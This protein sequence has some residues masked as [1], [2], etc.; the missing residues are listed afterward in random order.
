MNG[1][2]LRDAKQQRL[3]AQLR[4]FACIRRGKCGMLKE[5]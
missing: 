3:P 2:Q 1:G 4:G 5:V